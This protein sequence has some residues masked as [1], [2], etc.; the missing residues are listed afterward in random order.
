MEHLVRGA[1]TSLLKFDRVLPRHEE[2]SRATARIAASW[3]RGQQNEIPCPNHRRTP[4]GRPSERHTASSTR[5][6]CHLRLVLRSECLLGPSSENTDGATKQV[7]ARFPS[8]SPL[9]S[10]VTFLPFDRRMSMSPVVLAT[11][12]SSSGRADLPFKSPLLFCLPS[13]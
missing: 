6:R 11:R 8:E 3:C 12:S 5:R 7:K 13:P 10:D 9:L 4:A 1:H 2:D